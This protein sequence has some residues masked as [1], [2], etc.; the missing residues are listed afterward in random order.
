MIRFSTQYVS[1]PV[2]IIGGG[3]GSVNL[4]GASINYVPMFESNRSQVEN[5]NQ[6]FMP[7]AGTVSNFYVILNGS[8]GNNHWYTFVVRKNGADTPVT[9]TIA[10]TNT[11]GS[12]LTHSVSFAAGDY[13]SIMVT[14][15][16]ANPTGRVMLWTAKF[17]PSQ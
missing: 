14:P 4:Q 15:S 5:E 12:D 13:I 11:T 6:Q 7:V 16:A 17:W 9:C 2:Y 1:E 8:P 3:T 10:G